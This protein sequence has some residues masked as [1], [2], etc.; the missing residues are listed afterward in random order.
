MFLIDCPHCGARDESEFTCGG[1]AHIARPQDPD[2]VSDVQWAEYLFMRNNRKGLHFERWVHVHGCR[3]WFNLCRNTVT[4]EI[5][6]VYAMGSAPPNV[7]PAPSGAS[8]KASATTG[9]AK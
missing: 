2:Q 9:A 5:V 4:H 7:A 3:R 6:A 1:E 8:T